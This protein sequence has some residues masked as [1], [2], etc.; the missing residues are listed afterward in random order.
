MDEIR[1]ID[2]LGVK[3]TV[4]LVDTV[5]KFEPETGNINYLTHEIKIDKELPMSAREQVLTHEIL[6]GLFHL[7]GLNELRDDES[8]VQAIATGIHQIFSS[9]DIYE[10]IRGET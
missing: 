5:N 10:S 6:H 4:E 7:L 1:V 3:H 9:Q 2:I 8:K